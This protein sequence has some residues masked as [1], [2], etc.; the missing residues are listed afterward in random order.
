[1]YMK[2]LFHEVDDIKS[3]TLT[4]HFSSY[5]FYL[6]PSLDLTMFIILREPVVVVDL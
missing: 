5:F 1:M 4:G 2:L 3:L 6:C